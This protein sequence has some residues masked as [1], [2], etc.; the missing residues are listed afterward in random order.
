MQCHRIWL[1]RHTLPVPLQ[2]AVVGDVL[3]VDVLP[4]DVQPVDA[5]PDEPVMGSMAGVEHVAVAL[6]AKY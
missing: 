1:R 2:Y 3:H 5:P 6:H 4:E